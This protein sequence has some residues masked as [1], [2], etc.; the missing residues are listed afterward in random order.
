MIETVRCE[1][2]AWA[3]MTDLFLFKETKNSLHLNKA[4]ERFELLTKYTNPEGGLIFGSED[5]KV[6]SGENGL[7]CW[8][9]VKL[10]KITKDIIY[11]NQAYKWIKYVVHHPPKASPD[12]PR[13]YPVFLA[14]INYAFMELA[15]LQLTDWKE[16]VKLSEDYTKEIL[17]LQKHYKGWDI[18][19]HY[20][21]YV[22][23]NLLYAYHFFTIDQFNVDLGSKCFHA[24]LSFMKH[25]RHTKIPFM[26]VR[27]IHYLF[28]DW[29]GSGYSTLQYAQLRFELYLTYYNIDDYLEGRVALDSCRK[30][31]ITKDGSVVK[32]MGQKSPNKLATDWLRYVD[33]LN[34][35]C[36][37]IAKEWL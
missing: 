12:E 37:I 9:A 25:S 11:L 19:Y 24:L 8:G 36:E 22:A 10:Y 23:R 20:D 33:T 15:K 29:K 13:L 5:N 17:R 31:L 4:K 1:Y 27:P 14:W 16:W 7:A 30:Y 35:K 2:E 6:W 28:F 3:V 26:N 18:C 21:L 34:K 32:R